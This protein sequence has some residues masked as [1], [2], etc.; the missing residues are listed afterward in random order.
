M[1]KHIYI[2]CCLWTLNLFGQ[3][4]SN[5]DAQD[6]F[7]KTVNCLRVNDSI[8]FKNLHIS[9]SIIRN[10]NAVQNLQDAMS[11]FDCFNDLKSHLEV[12][13]INSIKPK[14]TVRPLYNSDTI[15][16]DKN[17]L[18]EISAIFKINRTF[19]KSVTFVTKYINNKLTIVEGCTLGTS[20]IAGK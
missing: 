14:V 3:K 1:K 7:T 13:V 6:I 4:P 19:T 18:Y 9:D 10:D 2:L 16:L 15:K 12:I 11:Y 17:V 20:E 8:G 5:K